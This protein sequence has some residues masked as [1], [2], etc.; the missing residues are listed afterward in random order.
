MV[1]FDIW[2]RPQY[3]LGPNQQTAIYIGHG[4]TNNIF[5]RAS[6]QV[7]TGGAVIIINEYYIDNGS[8]CIIVKNIDPNNW[9]VFFP[10]I[11]YC[12]P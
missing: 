2:T 9:T 4:R 8:I 11:L 10:S 12:T 3:V 5:C 6:V 7:V 1:N